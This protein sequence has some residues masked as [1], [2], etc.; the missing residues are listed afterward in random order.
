MWFGH[1]IWR[2]PWVG[3]RPLARSTY[4]RRLR[5]F[6]SDLTDAE[7]A[8]LWLLPPARSRTG[9][10]LQAELREVVNALPVAGVTALLSQAFDGSVLLLSESPPAL[11]FSTARRNHY[12]GGNGSVE[13]WNRRSVASIDAQK[14]RNSGRCGNQTPGISWASPAQRNHYRRKGRYRTPPPTDPSVH[15]PGLDH[16]RLRIDYGSSKMNRKLL[17]N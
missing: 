9:R 17:I 4:K 10:P 13:P 14:R 2:L 6:E 12:A 1:E 16:I 3:P 15:G 5:R 7:W 11:S 8:L